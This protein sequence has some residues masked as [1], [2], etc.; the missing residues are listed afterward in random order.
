MRGLS[1]I[2]GLGFEGSGRFWRPVGLE[3]GLLVVR[4]SV[5]LF[6]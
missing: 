1:T 2:G 3:E 4:L 5:A 6:M